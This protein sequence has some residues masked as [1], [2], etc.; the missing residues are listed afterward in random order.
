MQVERTVEP[1]LFVKHFMLLFMCDTVVTLLLFWLVVTFELMLS[2]STSFLV[3]WYLRHGCCWVSRHS[4]AIQTHSD[5]CL[6]LLK[7]V[8]ST[9][10]KQHVCWCR[11]SCSQSSDGR[12]GLLFSN[13]RMLHLV[14]LKHGKAFE[15]HV[16]VGNRTAFLMGGV[17]QHT[18]ESF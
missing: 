15:L 18:G 8:E 9:L 4:T 16:L 12:F 14:S 2:M 17:E 5:M 13:I 7:S 11:L 3:L 10:C 1:V 6:V